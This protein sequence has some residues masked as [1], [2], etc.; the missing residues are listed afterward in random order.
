[1]TGRSRSRRAELPPSL[2]LTT[3]RLVLSALTPAGAADLLAG[4]VAPGR[5]R[6]ADYPGQDDVVAATAYLWALEHVGDFPPYGPYQLVRRADAVV[7]GGAGFHGPPVGGEVEIAYAVV[8]SARG[9][10]YATEAIRAL[11]DLAAASGARSVS[12]VV[13]ADNVASARVA[14]AA[15]FV[16]R[17]ADAATRRYTLTP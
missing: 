10:G 14:L 11:V 3:A 13:A 1:M 16:V 7:I 6:A 15:G 4:I 12:A 9:N 8:P 5:T 17:S 2:Q